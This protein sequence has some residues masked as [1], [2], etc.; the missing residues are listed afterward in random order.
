MTDEPMVERLTKARK[1][2]LTGISMWQSEFS[3]GA[4]DDAAFDE[5]ARLVDEAFSD[6]I[7]LL[8]QLRE[9]RERADY[10]QQRAEEAEEVVGSL[11]MERDEL[12][13]ANKSYNG[14][15][16]AMI[17]AE[18]TIREQ[19]EALERIAG[20]GGRTGVQPIGVRIARDA[21]AALAPDTEGEN[22]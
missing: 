2:A 20:L 5:D 18:R 21:L 6:A 8:S 13:E 14:R 15:E 9:Q 22:R 11:T 19:R 10:W 7:A 12:R 1:I 3:C 16:Q 17:A 4:E